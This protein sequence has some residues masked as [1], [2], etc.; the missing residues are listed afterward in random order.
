M[1]KVLVSSLLVLSVLVVGL[2]V[3]SFIA[4]GDGE[5]D[6]T[7]AVSG[8]LVIVRMVEI[9]GLKP[10]KM[11]VTYENGESETIAL[12]SFMLKNVSNNMEILMK[13]LNEFFKKDYELISSTGGNSD[14][15]FVNTYILQKK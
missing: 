7:E 9:W 11:I 10:S 12:K 13:K 3:S 6:K 2:S 4:D 15:V 5:G 8:D 14:G 1:K